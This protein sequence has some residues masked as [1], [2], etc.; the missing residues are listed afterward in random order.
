[1]AS[2]PENRNFCSS[3]LAESRTASLPSLPDTGTLPAADASSPWERGD[4]TDLLGDAGFNQVHIR[5]GVHQE[6][7]GLVAIHINA[8]H[9]GT[10]VPDL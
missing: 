1:M 4:H 6:P 9:D 2:N 7:V 10:D 3:A 8:V 5:P